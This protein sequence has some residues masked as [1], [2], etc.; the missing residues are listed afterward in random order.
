MPVLVDDNTTDRQEQS[1]VKTA[2]S[3]ETD[4]CDGDHHHHVK[5][6][7]NDNNNGDYV[8]VAVANTNDDKQDHT[9]SSGNDENQNHRHGLLH[10]EDAKKTM[11]GTEDDNDSH[12]RPS[13]PLSSK[14]G[15]SGGN[16]SGG[17]S[18]GGG[19]SSG[20]HCVGPFC[21]CLTGMRKD[22]KARVPLYLD[23]WKVPNKSSFF[24]VFNATIF[25]FVVQL[26]P[27]LIFAELLDKNT[28]G[29]LSVAETLMSTGIIGIMYALLSGQPLV[30]V[31][32]T[33]CV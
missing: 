10:N 7:D 12:H 25:A 19:N 11:L 27:S 9:S 26:I 14:G 29:S 32:I 17:N 6:N 1:K 28:H 33:G 23:D 22:L 13:S 15:S 24:K 18:G 20:G 16:S 3:D 2:H 31:G 21:S 5:W 30:L 4:D 8:A